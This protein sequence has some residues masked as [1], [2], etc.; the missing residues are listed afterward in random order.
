MV[1]TFVTPSW[2]LSGNGEPLELNSTREA[3][4]EPEQFESNSLI[5]SCSQAVWICP[6]E[7]LSRDKK[8]RHTKD[9]WVTANCPVSFSSLDQWSRL[10][11]VSLSYSYRSKRLPSDLLVR[12]LMVCES[13][14]KKS[15]LL[16]LSFSFFL[17]LSLSLSLSLLNTRDWWCPLL[18]LPFAISVFTEPFVGKRANRQTGCSVN[19]L[20]QGLSTPTH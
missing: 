18:S 8:E 11:C 12:R 16:A 7:N 13:S 6:A 5:F 1:S 14:S 4:L 19:V 10:R 15:S 9:D 2:T 3:S 17:S 20:S